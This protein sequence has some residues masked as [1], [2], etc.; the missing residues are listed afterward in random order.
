MLIFDISMKV[1]LRKKLFICKITMKTFRA[2][3]FK[4]HVTA[5]GFLNWNY[6]QVDNII[7][8][9]FVLIVLSNGSK[10]VEFSSKIQKVKVVKTYDR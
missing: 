7:M 3:N 9:L 10:S 5:K 2:Q 4:K 6:Y 1:I 8:Q